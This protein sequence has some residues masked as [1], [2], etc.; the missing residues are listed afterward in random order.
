MPASIFKSV[1]EKVSINDDPVLAPSFVTEGRTH[2][3]ST[4]SI[5]ATFWSTPR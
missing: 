2:R 5:P 3:R 1:Y 4:G